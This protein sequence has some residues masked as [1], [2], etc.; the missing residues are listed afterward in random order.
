MTDRNKCKGFFKNFNIS[1]QY[2]WGKKK[3]K[4]IHLCR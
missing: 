3:I 2:L 4:T 1:K